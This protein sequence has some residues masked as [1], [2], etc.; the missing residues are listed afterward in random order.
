MLD[1]MEQQSVPA[2]I[3]S[4]SFRNIPFGEKQMSD[5][6]AILASGQNLVESICLH[7]TGIGDD[8]A[9]RLF[10]ILADNDTGVEHVD[11]SRCHL[12]RASSEH[13]QRLLLP[14]PKP[15][16]VLT[17]CP[18]PVCKHRTAPEQSQWKPSQ[19][20]PVP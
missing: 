7:G 8:L 9:C 19:L 1:H 5:L 10:G 2:K 3:K 12:T 11:L 17:G 18:S 15:C 20:G 16:R 4:I 6:I 14:P 13:I